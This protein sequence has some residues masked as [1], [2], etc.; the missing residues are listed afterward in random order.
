MRQYNEAKGGEKDM[1]ATICMTI[2]GLFVLTAIL[3]VFFGV[4]GVVLW[5]I[6]FAFK[7]VFAV[8]GIVFNILFKPVVLIAL[9]VLLCIAF[10]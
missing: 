7:I 5:V 6:G 1:V 10:F 2:L 9:I 4:F 3:S 8:V